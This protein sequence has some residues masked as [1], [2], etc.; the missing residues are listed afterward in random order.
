MEILK[1]IDTNM[2]HTHQSVQARIA[3]LVPDV[4]KLEFGCLIKLPGRTKLYKVTGQEYEDRDMPGC[5]F[6]PIYRGQAT[7]VGNP[8]V[9]T[10]EIIGRDATL[11]D[12]LRALHEVKRYFEVYTDGAI[13]EETGYET[14]KKHGKWNLSLPLSGQSQETIDF[15]G[16]LIK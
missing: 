14:F 12:F 8:E 9:R 1:F 7:C 13:Y 16:N 5:I 11:A 10:I 4:L 15:I 6:V 2:P 3:E